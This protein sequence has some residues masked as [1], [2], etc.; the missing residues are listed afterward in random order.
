MKTACSRHLQVMD[1]LVADLVE[2]HP[3]TIVLFGSMARHLADHRA[4]RQ[5]RDLD[6]LFVGHS[7]PVGLRFKR[8]DLEYD[9]QL[10]RVEQLTALAKSLRYDSKAVL[11]SKL[12]SGVMVRGHARGVIAA[13]LLLGSDYRKIGIEQIE[14]DG[15]TDPRDYSVHKVLHGRAWWN[16]ISAY[17]RERR[18]AVQTPERPT[19]GPV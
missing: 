5:P 13:C 9:L 16:G 3:K 2:Y 10:F 11:L 7:M 1:Q 18:G 15:R 14:I 12:Y 19:G 8:Y 17:A 4:A 6:L